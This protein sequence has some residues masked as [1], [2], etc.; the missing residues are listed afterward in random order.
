MKTSLQSLVIADMTE[1]QKPR[2]T[3]QIA[4]DIIEKTGQPTNSTCVSTVM[5]TLKNHRDHALEIT[6]PAG[7]R[8][9][10]LK[11]SLKEITQQ[12]EQ[13]LWALRR[14]RGNA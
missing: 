7:N 4:L 5:Q 9:Y 10:R 2:S 12:V 13:Q 3:R 1:N 14:A 6:G 8:Q 11:S